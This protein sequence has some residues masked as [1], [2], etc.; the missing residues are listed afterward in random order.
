MYMTEKLKVYLKDLPSTER[1]GSKQT[2]RILRRK[3]AAEVARVFPDIELYVQ[4]LEAYN[5]VL[6]MKVAAAAYGLVKSKD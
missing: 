3:I 6:S 2:K 5:Q 1:L 4:G